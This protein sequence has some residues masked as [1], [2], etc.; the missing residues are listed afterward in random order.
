MTTAAFRAATVDDFEFFFDL[1]KATLGPYV[2]QVWGW[3][4]DHQRAYLRS[5]IELAATQVIVVDGADVGR[6]TL[7]D[8]DGD[9]YVGL[10]EVAANLQRRGIGTRVLRAV[11]DDA[12][13]AGRGV[14][15]NVL[16]VNTDAYRLYRRLGFVVVAETDIRRQMRAHPPDVE[17]ATA[18]MDL[19]TT[20]T[21]TAVRLRAATPGDQGFVVHMARHAC[22][23]EGWPLPDPDDDEVLEMLPVPGTV[24]ILAEDR[25][26]SPVGAAWTYTSS[27]PLR[28]DAAGAPLPELCIAVA[29]GH[30]GAGVGAALLDA[31]FAELAQRFDSMCTNVHVRNP[32]R[33][34]YERKGF[35]DVGQ[36]HGPLGIAMIKDL[37]SVG[38]KSC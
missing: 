28:T 4:D 19:A 33:R 11:L 37:R 21:A 14:C 31:L 27:P 24:A 1:H 25:H 9:V 30:R 36:G 38:D 17:S 26:G 13:T 29:P 22:V 5:T 10:I 20:A 16:R 7:A 2:D 3:D 18:T 12:F 15:L 32:A 6:L 35:R 34:L 23:I 8:Q